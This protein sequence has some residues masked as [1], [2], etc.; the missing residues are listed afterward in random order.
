MALSARALLF[1]ILAGIGIGTCYGGSHPPVDEQS[2]C[3]DCHA[4]HGTA[5]YP[6]PALKQGCLAC[7]RIQ[8][9]ESATYVVLK[10]VKPIVCRECH[11]ADQALH[12]HFPYSS[13]MCLRCHDPHGSSNP[14][15]LRAKANDLC[16]EC[17]LRTSKTGGSRYLPTLDLTMNN[18]MGHPYERHPVSGYPDPLTGGELSCLSCHFAHGGTMVH[19]LKMGSEIP[20]DALNHNTE[21]I[22]MCHKCHLRMW[23]FDGRPGKKAKKSKH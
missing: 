15:L 14:R 7:H 22:D 21:T 9:L 16:L 10:P 2:N 1:A 3:L 4:D 6:H 11:D 8:N 20:E 19:Y 18:T 13:A 12:L 23:G 5:A 17:H